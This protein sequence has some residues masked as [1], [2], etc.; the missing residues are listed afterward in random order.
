MRDK[1]LPIDENNS[2]KKQYF[3]LLSQQSL[4][5]RRDAV[6]KLRSLGVVVLAQYTTVAIVGRATPK[7][8]ESA[9]RT[10]LFTAA[11]KGV[12]SKEHME[13][14][15]T[16]EERRVIELW[17]NRFTRSYREL[18]KDFTHVGKAW[19][20]PGFDEPFAYS[21][22]GVEDF[23][24]LVKKYEDKTGKPILKDIL[25]KDTSIGR[26]QVKLSPK[27]FVAYEQKLTDVYKDATLAYHL[28]RLALQF[29]SKYYSV[30]LKLPREFLDLLL[31]Y[32]FAEADCW[33]MKGEISVGIV[34]VESS[35]SG[36]PK[37]STSERNSICDEIL[38]GQ[39]WLAEQQPY[40]N[41]SWVY[42]FQFITIDVANGNNDSEEAYWRNPA[43]GEV[44]Y[45][46]NSY[47]AAWSGVGDYREDM[48]TNNRSAHA[49]VIFVT[50]YG[51]SWHAYASSGRVTLA[52]RNNWGGWGQGT[53]DMITA[54]ETS[55][56]FGSSDEYTGSGTP[57]SSCET[58]HGCYQLPNGNCGSCASPHQSCVMDGNSRRLC[59]YTKGH[60]G[61][62]DI[63]IETT[64]ADVLWAGTDDDVWLDIG[65][66]TY[67]LDTANHDDRERGNREGYALA[68]SSVTL[69]KIKR[70]L[71]RKSSDGFAGGWKLQGVRVWYHA[72]LI[73][74]NG[75]INKWLEDEERFWVGCVSDPTIVASLTVKITTADV[76]WAGTDDDVTITFGGK[77]WG[78]DNE[79]HDDF[80]RGN[81]DTFHLDPKTGLYVGDI[82]SVK[83][84]KSPDGFAGGW[85][86]KGVQIIVNGVSIYN[87]QGI[88][89]WLEDNDRDWMDSF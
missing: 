71:I 36:G 59:A 32:F 52:K 74:N 42:D 29:G 82:H 73:C 14:L 56:L 77:S 72:D 22:I 48:R 4:S 12:F 50:P 31:E 17:N 51:N 89:K 35:Q 34:F 63:F 85:K 37:F 39:A 57:C 81:T 9:Q 6:D 10:G 75:G 80:E 83:V 8:I 84:H 44:S 53:I 47:A 28:S 76:L 55:H 15:K 3:F 25:Q 64:T 19:A 13:K 2:E 79:G 33:V 40:G 61:W 67:I 69:A 60:I 11:I 1:N 5:F 65:D 30:F 45:N 26:R 78:L 70:I 46:G 62:A 86:L 18:Q 49:M 66:K 7:Q 21:K 43:M 16:D 41:L 20:T 23:L 27:E 54:H 87:N 58:K 24:Q 68:D 88:N 38:E